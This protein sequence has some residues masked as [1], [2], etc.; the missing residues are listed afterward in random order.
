METCY[1]NTAHPDFLNGHR[2]MA[3]INDKISKNSPNGDKNRNTLHA[4]GSNPL[5]DMDSQNSGFFG[6]FFNTAKKKKAG[7]MEP[8]I[9]IQI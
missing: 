2:A 9:V 7:L 3:I 8:V 1:I 4:L 5:F 6:T